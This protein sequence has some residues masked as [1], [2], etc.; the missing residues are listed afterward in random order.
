MDDE[1][2]V[3]VEKERVENVV[4]WVYEKD[5]FTPS[6]KIVDNECYTIISDYLGTPT[7]VYN[8]S[9]EKVWKRELDICGDVKTEDGIKNL[10][11]FR[12]Q[13]Q[14][15]D[16]EIELCYNR[17]RYY[18]VENGN[19]ISQEPI[20][21]LGGLP[22][23]YGYVMDTNKF[24][25]VF[26]LEHGLSTEVVRDAKTVF[27]SNYVSG[28]EKGGG[29]LNQQEA[30]L[31]HTERK[32]LND[33]DGMVKPGDHLKMTGELNPCRPGCQP[34]IRD[35][36]HAKGVTAEYTASSTGKVYQWE[37]VDNKFVLQTEIDMDG[38][39]TTYKYNIAKRKRVKYK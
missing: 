26:G 31:T 35:F 37:R 21:L 16:T 2:N 32:F 25:D 38:S 39:K 20:G 36:V 14:Y 24:I 34:A 18:N 10:I 23:F 22:N 5:R 33:V 27:S 12:Y 17:F 6:T 30:L 13:G 4:T 28:G 9:G 7:Q 1:G 19:Y 29:R 8:K 3:V 11:P 15:Y